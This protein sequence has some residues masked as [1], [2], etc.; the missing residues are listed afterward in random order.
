MY[1]SIK[2]RLI[3]L[4]I[5]FTVLPIILLRL[6][7]YPRMQADLQDIL[8][9][10]LD[11]IGHKQAELV[12]NWIHERTEDAHVIAS[13]PMIAKCVNIA[14]DDKDCDDIYQ[15]LEVVKKEYGYKGILISNHEGIV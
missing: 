11:G 13:N 2:S 14:K 1:I 8:I 7:A 15:Y 5:T 6:V 12:T 4:L 10:N 9:R 3:M